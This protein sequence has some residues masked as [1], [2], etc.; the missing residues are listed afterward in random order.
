[1]TTSSRPRWSPGQGTSGVTAPEDPE[2]F[3]PPAP[4]CAKCGGAG[5]EPDESPCP[6]CDGWGMVYMDEGP[7]DA[8]SLDVEPLSG[9][10]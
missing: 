1:M 6:L 2:R 8:E 10:G 7:D 5:I 4:L 3:V 9:E